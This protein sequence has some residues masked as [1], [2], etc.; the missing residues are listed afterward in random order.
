MFGDAPLTFWEFAMKD[1]LPVGKIQETLFQF[2]HGREDVVLFGAQAVNAYVSAARLTEDIDI[3]AVDA[4]AFAEEV[5]AFLAGEFHIAV[6]I[7]HVAKGAGFRVYQVRKPDN[8]HLVDV[9]QVDTLPPADCVAGVMVMKPE[10]LVA[11]KVISLA[12]RHD[13]PK[14]G[15][16]RRD[17]AYMLLTFPAFKRMEGPVA[18]ELAKLE[19]PLRAIE[20]WKEIVE[21][22]LLPEDED[23]GY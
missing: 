23:E 16:D 5:R 22:P 7:R 12:Q 13:R 6:R 3:M 19:A 1:P 18:E 14:A 4:E 2:L 10:R 15:T 8:R 20:V 21:A 9:R 11:S 17:I